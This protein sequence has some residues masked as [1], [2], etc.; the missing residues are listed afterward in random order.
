VFNSHE[1][2]SHDRDPAV[3]E[4]VWRGHWTIEN[5]VH[6]VHDVTMGE[7]AGQAHTGSTPQALAAVRNA[8]L[9]LLRSRGWTNIA[10][11]LRHYAASLDAALELIGVRPARL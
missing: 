3:L 2:G 10:D 6:Y 7:D 4:G 11:A 1:T 8:L 5:R 9:A